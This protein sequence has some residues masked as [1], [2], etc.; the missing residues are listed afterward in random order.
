MSGRVSCEGDAGPSRAHSSPHTCRNAWTAGQQR[1]HC[2]S[3][4][5][6]GVARSRMGTAEYL[7]VRLRSPQQVKRVLPKLEDD[8]GQ[9]WSCS[10]SQKVVV[11]PAHGR[12]MGAYS[13]LAVTSRSPT[14][15]GKLLSS[16]LPS[17]FFS[18]GPDC[19]L[20]AHRTHHTKIS[21]QRNPPPTLPRCL[22]QNVES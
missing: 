9:S 11:S 10:A 14:A 22:P 1:A 4:T 16:H 13:V 3:D 2:R 21:W 6:I 7:T 18:P 15:F 5:S 8:E 17:I 20:A 12:H 19:C